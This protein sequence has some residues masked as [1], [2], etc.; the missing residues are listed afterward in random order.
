M[1]Q[2]EFYQAPCAFTMQELNDLIGE[3]NKDYQA[4]ISMYITGYSVAQPAPL[5]LFSTLLLPL[6]VNNPPELALHQTCSLL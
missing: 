2:N 4:I 6:A 3:Y 5:L 1:T